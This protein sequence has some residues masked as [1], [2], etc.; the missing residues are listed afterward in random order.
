MHLPPL[1]LDG[2]HLRRE[3]LEPNG[4]ATLVDV[5]DL[6]SPAAR[7]TAT[8]RPNGCGHAEASLASDS[9]EGGKVRAWLERAHEVDS[10]LATRWADRDAHL[11]D[12][13]GRTRGSARINVLT[14]EGHSDVRISAVIRRLAVIAT[15]LTARTVFIH[16]SELRV[17]CELRVTRARSPPGYKLD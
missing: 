2:A 4:A 8:R 17:T 14:C 11:D 5:V 13:F 6:G 3:G 1:D 9:D 16:A 7:P 15:A 12:G 10:V